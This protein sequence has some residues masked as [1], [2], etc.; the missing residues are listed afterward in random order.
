MDRLCLTKSLDIILAGWQS[1]RMVMTMRLNI[2]PASTLT[3]VGCNNKKARPCQRD[4]DR[5]RAVVSL[6]NKPTGVSALTPA[7]VFHPNVSGL[8]DTSKQ[9]NSLSLRW[10][11]RSRHGA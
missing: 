1:E 7:P 11:G 4:G 3:D 2:A 5:R 8:A 9:A 10:P 6:T